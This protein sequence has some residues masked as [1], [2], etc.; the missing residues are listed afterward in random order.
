MLVC[1]AV[2]GLVVALVTAPRLSRASHRVEGEQGR[3]A[4]FWAVV[5]VCLVVG[6]LAGAGAGLIDPV[7]GAFVGD[8]ATGGGG[9]GPLG[10]TDVVRGTVY[11]ALAAALV[12]LVAIDLDVHRLPNAW[13]YRL[14]VITPL[15]LGALALLERD[16]GAW[17]RALTAALA[18]GL[19]YLVLVI[20]GGGTGMGLG[21]LKLAP[22][23]G[24]LLGFLSWTHVVLGTTAGFVLG[25]VVA[26]FLL[27]R[28]GD[29]TSHLAFGPW[30]VAGTVLVAALP[31]LGLVL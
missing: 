11:A 12:V 10:W 29:R 22:T 9:A 20:V 5:P 1:A 18:V 3:V 27:V 8:E 19:L 21:D 6:A 31:M 30:M 13:T 7:T 28:G 4:R 15:T 23:L 26:A 14:L 25:G 16:L 17:L 24:M 2:A